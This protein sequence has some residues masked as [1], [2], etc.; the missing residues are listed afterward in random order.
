MIFFW[1]IEQIGGLEKGVSDPE[2]E[3][4]SALFQPAQIYLAQ[5]P[6]LILDQ[7]Q[8]GLLSGMVLGVKS[9]IPSDL[10]KALRRTS[11]IHIVVV[12]G[13]NLT[14]LAGLIL[15]LAPLLGRRKVIVIGL[16][17]VLVY[18]LIS[19]L[20]VPVIRAAIMVTF[21][22]L[23]KLLG[24][25]EDSILVLLLTASIMLIYNP[26][27]LLSVSF[28]L[29]FLATIGVVILAP[30]IINRFGFI[31]NLI[32]QDLA[33]SLA[34][35][36]MTLPVIAFQFHQISLVG[37]LTNSL[38]LFTIP[39]IM[40]SGSVAIFVSLINL[41]LGQLLTVIPAI[42]LTYFIYIVELFNTKWASI[43]MGKISWLVWLGYYILILATFIFLKQINGRKKLDPG[44]NF[45]G[46]F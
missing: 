46:K 14:M 37:I 22:S 23:A 42:F 3:K 24:R 18:A 44:Q 35:Q 38:I 25:E 15:N 17:A 33:V 20:Q 41:T 36:I 16:L 21:A 43:Y 5:Q 19:G 26:N 1:R 7:P 31:P 2:I 29:S 28:Q 32:K 9:L 40:V 30:E 4:I 8:A 34:A 6:Q 10:T 27:W 13:Q 11:T 12:S 45:M 39:I